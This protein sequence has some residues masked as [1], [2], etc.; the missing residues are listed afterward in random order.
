MEYHWTLEG[1]PMLLKAGFVLV[2]AGSVMTAVSLSHTEVD[3]LVLY[4]WT[5]RIERV[6]E[7]RRRT[8]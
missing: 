5:V 1:G 6:Y 3:F 8:R 4:Y 7:S 2:D